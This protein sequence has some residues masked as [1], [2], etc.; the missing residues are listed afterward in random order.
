[1]L[2]GAQGG[3]CCS[4]CAS[5]RWPSVF[6]ASQMP[7]QNE[8]ECIHILGRNLPCPGR[9]GLCWDYTLLGLMMVLTARTCVASQSI[10]PYVRL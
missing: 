1:M 6:C 5:G 4:A 2:A 3:S 7:T 9:S 8:A 10:K